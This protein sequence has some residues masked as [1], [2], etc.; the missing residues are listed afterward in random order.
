MAKILLVYG[1]AYGQTE[2]IARR[3][4]DQLTAHGHGVCMY[5]G[6]SL[7]ANLPLDR[8][9][10]FVVAASVI[11][12]RYQRYIRDFV[13]CQAGRLGAV[14]SAFVSV[15][16]TAKDSPQQAREHAESFLRQS[17]WRPTFIQ[18]FAG[19]VAYTQYG[20]FLRWIMK[21]ISQR[22]GGP[23]DTTHDYDFT[24]WAAVDRFAERLTEAVPPA[25]EAERAERLLLQSGHPTV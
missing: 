8:Y 5:K 22:Q 12:G 9:D 18:T 23:T 10:A 17:G 24:D 4:V 13:R 14:P 20:L 6:E 25:P 7:P 1:T 3:I 2:R 11:R 15:S 16:G 19:A 21:R